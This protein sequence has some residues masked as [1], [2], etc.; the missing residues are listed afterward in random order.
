MFLKAGVLIPPQ[1]ASA[2]SADHGHSVQRADQK[3]LIFYV[4]R[5]CLSMRVIVV[6]LFQK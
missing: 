5:L 1:C 3:G 4:R 6:D 2:V